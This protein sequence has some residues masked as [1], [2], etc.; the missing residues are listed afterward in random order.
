MTGDQQRAIEFLDAYADTLRPNTSSFA[1]LEGAAGVGKTWLVAHWLERYAERKPKARVLVTA[2]TNKAVDVLRSKCGHLPVGF[3]TLDSYLGY[4]VKRDEDR[5][6]QRSR[7]IQAADQEPPSLL[8]VDEASMVKEEYHKELGHMRVP[9]LYVGDPYQLQPVGETAS[10]AFSVTSRIRMLE[11][12]RQAADSPIHGLTDFLRNRVEDNRTFV[13][14][15]L[16]VLA[17]KDDSRFVFTNARNVRDWAE[18]AIEKGLDCR[19]IAFTNAAVNEQNAAMHAIMY[20]SAPLFGVGELALV[21]EA[22]EY[23][24]D[25]ML[26]N[27]EMLRVNSCEEVAPVAGNV[28]VFEVRANQLKNS[29]DV[30]GDVDDNEL[31]LKVALD[32][33]HA[34]RVHRD[35][36]D[37]IYAARRTGD[38]ANADR[39][40]EERAPLNKLAPLRHSYASTVHKSQ[41]STYDVAI[42]DFPDIYRS[43]E[44]RARLMYV[45]ASRPSQFL[46]VSHTA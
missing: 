22:F 24:D 2:P 4:R 11:P 18:K 25:L 44:M 1:C 40:L 15:D 7:N 28:R 35:L 9:V 12:T 45:G 43:R 23:S 30:S 26:L 20:P 41:G 36:T 38:I 17:K 34:L 8:V 5:Q 21:N 29:L 27:G 39:Y 42:V 13:L 37:K 31:V 46:V 3:R 10:L 14:Q 33:E 32:S 19:I 6:M 16:R